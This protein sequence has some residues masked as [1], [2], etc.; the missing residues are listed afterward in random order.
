MAKEPTDPPKKITFDEEDPR[1]VRWAQL[2]ALA[3]VECGGQEQASRWMHTPKL[4]AL[5]GKTPLMAM[6]TEEGCNAVENLLR[7][8]NQ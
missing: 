5:K 7:E 6:A 4:V 8:L 3:I 1:V 2:T